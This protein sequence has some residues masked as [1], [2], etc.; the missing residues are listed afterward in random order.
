[1]CKLLNFTDDPLMKKKK[2]DFIMFIYIK[3]INKKLI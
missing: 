1:M 3:E 2:L